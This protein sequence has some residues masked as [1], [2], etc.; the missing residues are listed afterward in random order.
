[1]YGEIR[2]NV[3]VKYDPAG[4]VLWNKILLGSYPYSSQG[5]EGSHI[6]RIKV[7]A[8]GDIFFTGYSKPAAFGNLDEYNLETGKMN[9]N[10]VMEWLVNYDQASLEDYAVNLTLD[11]AGNLLV[12][13]KTE[14]S[15]NTFEMLTI[16]YCLNCLQLPSVSLQLPQDTFCFLNTPVT[17]SGGSP[18]G[19]AYSGDGVSNGVFN[20][21]TA[22]IGEHEI[23][24]SYSDSAGCT[25]FEAQAVY[26]DV[27]A[28]EQLVV[29]DYHLSVFPNPFSDFTTIQFSLE[30]NLNLK[31]ELQDLS[32]RKIKTIAEENFE[33]GIHQLIF[34]A[35]DLPKGIYLLQLSLLNAAGETGSGIQ[36]QLIIQ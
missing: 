27:C 9:K 19:G 11:K 7:N 4:N 1:V 18:A 33:A 14:T 16:K 22:G 13:G 5:A 29:G 34:S 31:V 28:G 10:G 2:H 24:Y 32:G 17:L 23:V 3:M 15:A 20:P 21:F 8:A 6:S 30:K 12:I 25:N 36:K 35:E 26:V